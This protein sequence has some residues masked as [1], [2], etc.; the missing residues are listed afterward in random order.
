MIPFFPQPEKD[1]TIF[2]VV[3]RFSSRFTSHDNTIIK[4][5]TG[6][7]N[8]KT[9][10]SALPGNIKHLS[11]TV[12][13]GHPWRN[14]EEIILNHSNL[15]Y[16]LYFNKQYSLSDWVNRLIKHS[17]PIRYEI[18]L[19]LRSYKC[20]AKPKHPRFCHLCMNDDLYNKG[21]SIFRREHQLPGVLFCW[22]H[23]VLLS[24]GCNV[25]GFYPL[26]GKILFMA[27]KCYCQE[28]IQPLFTEESIKKPEP[29]IW[30]A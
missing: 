5:L 27:G 3:S 6:S 30:I 10:L 1:E 9:L 22:K 17:A 19:G 14:P 16:F 11:E 15:N 7:I 2:S 8:N 28:G 20:L 4:V 24:V 12:P 26:K 13:I 18:A 25:C 29:L 23:Q 21:F